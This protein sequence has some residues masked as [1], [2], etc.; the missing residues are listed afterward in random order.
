MQPQHAWSLDKTD[1]CQSKPQ[2][3]EMLPTTTI[4]E[5]LLVA[6]SPSPA[7]PSSW[8]A[9]C[10]HSHCRDL[11]FFDAGAACA[12]LQSLHMKA[13]G[14]SVTSYPRHFGWYLSAA[15]T[16]RS[17]VLSLPMCAGANVWHH[18]RLQCLQSCKMKR[19]VDMHRGNVPLFAL[20]AHHH[21]QVWVVWHL[22]DA[23]PVEGTRSGQLGQYGTICRLRMLQLLHC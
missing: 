8:G 2:Q 19:W 17:V 9:P 4:V 21:E 5:V 10:Q 15:T 22:A 16:A 20:V 11:C 1:R 14:S 13:S 23:V 6:G 12:F 18:C 3:S 7:P